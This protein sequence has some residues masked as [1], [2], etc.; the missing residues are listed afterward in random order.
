MLRQPRWELPD[1]F[2]RIANE[3]SGDYWTLGSSVM[4]AGTYLGTETTEG[5]GKSGERNLEPE[6]S[7]RA[8]ASSGE[9]DGGQLA[10]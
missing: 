9:S 8:G 7:W 6:D 4:R 5:S 3:L 2:R 10:V 1:L